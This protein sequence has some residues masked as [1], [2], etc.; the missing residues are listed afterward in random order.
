MGSDCLDSRKSHRINTYV[1]WLWNSLERKHLSISKAFIQLIQNT[2]KYTEPCRCMFLFPLWRN[3]DIMF[4]IGYWNPV[5]G[6]CC[7]RS[8]NWRLWSRKQPLVLVCGC[9]LF[10]C[11]TYLDLLLLAA[12]QRFYQGELDT[13]IT[14]ELDYASI[15]VLSFKNCS[16]KNRGRC[17]W[18]PLSF[19]NF[20]RCNLLLKYSILQI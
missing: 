17:L 16:I 3:H 15:K 11:Y 2:F 13:L 7:S 10:H 18:D 5:H 14:R 4:Y 20:I 12:S 19:T 6:L 1:T 8:S 9:H